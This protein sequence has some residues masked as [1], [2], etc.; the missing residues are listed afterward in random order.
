MDDQEATTTRRRGLGFFIMLAL[1]IVILIGGL[2]SIGRLAIDYFVFR[3]NP[4]LKRQYSEFMTATVDVPDQPGGKPG[5]NEA[6]T[7]ATLKTAGK[8]AGQPD[9]DALPP[10]M[11]APPISK[12]TQAAVARMF[13]IW[14]PEA[15]GDKN[16]VQ[17]LK[18]LNESRFYDRIPP[19]QLDYALLGGELAKAA[20]MLESFEAVISRPDYEIDAMASP[21]P[22]GDVPSSPQFLMTLNGAKMLRLKALMLAHEGRMEEALHVA[23]LATRAS[24]ACQYTMLITQLI[25]VAIN[26]IGTNTWAEV[27]GQCTDPALLRRTL[28]R[29]NA[30]LKQCDFLSSPAPVLMIDDLGA[31]RQLR[32]HGQAVEYENLTAQQIRARAREGR[33][34]YLKRVVR[35]A[36]A[37]D[38]KMAEEIEK[39][40]ADFQMQSAIFGG[41]AYSAVGACRKFVASFARPMLF[42]MAV[43][44][45]EE[46]KTRAKI[47]RQYFELLRAETARRIFQLEKGVAPVRLGDVAPQYI[48][49]VPSDV[50]SA[51]PKTTLREAPEHYYSIGPDRKDDAGAILYDPTNGTV[52][53]GD[54]F[55]KRQ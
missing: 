20:K 1:I 26:R 47:S 18:T 48:P 52:S 46:G 49:E 44:N 14:N 37:G 10:G 30:M 45:F 16:F 40:I 12:E 9:P 11:D 32:R 53:G 17:Q 27:V 23:E 25:G 39:R 15:T 22:F 8:T 31:I 38:P 50:F 24:R 29:Q 13:A 2:M 7:S 51:Q 35:P 21:G 43:P 4:D 41:H 33:V 5:A 19:N 6:S 34:E 54:I 28:E 42:R 55:L 36:A 3:N